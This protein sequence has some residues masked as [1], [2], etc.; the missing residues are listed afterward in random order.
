MLNLGVS[1][2]NKFTG[3]VGKQQKILVTE[4]AFHF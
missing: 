2:E 1:D 4:L 3:R